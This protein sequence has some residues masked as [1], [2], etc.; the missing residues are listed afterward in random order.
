MQINLGGQKQEEALLPHIRG[1]LDLFPGPRTGGGAPTWTIHDPLA[2]RYFRIGWLEFEILTHWQAGKPAKA[3]VEAMRD[4]PL[5]DV[6]EKDV[7]A[8]AGFLAMSQ[9]VAVTDEGGTGQLLT[10]SRAQKTGIMSWILK[11]YLYLKVPLVRPDAFL[12]RAMSWGRFFFTR[13]YLLLISGLALLGLWLISHEW[14]RWKADLSVLK[15]PEGLAITAVMLFLSKIVHEFGHG[16]AAKYYGCRVPR[17]GI[18]LILLWPVLWTDTTAAWSLTD[19]RHRLVIDSAGVIAELSVAAVATILWALAPDGIIKQALHILSGV[20]W[21]MTL[22]VNANPFMR[23][24]GY[25]ILADAVDIPNLQERAFAHT[26]WWLRRRLLGLVEDPP[27]RWP[28]QTRRFL[29]PYALA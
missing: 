8:V 9:L 29:I 2:G 24:D 14:S 10:R 21:I 16:L 4:R 1:D 22:V 7:M 20:A 11:N 28:L 15:T 6:D 17:M 26:K 23:F 3:V 13:G 18:A 19:R 27:E 5:V 25:Y 12:T